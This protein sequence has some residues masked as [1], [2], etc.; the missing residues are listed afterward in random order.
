MELHQTLSDAEF[1]S[2]FRACTLNPAL[3][4]HEAHLR[5]AWIHIRQYGIEQ[6]IKN[7]NAQLLKFVAHVGATDKFNKTVTICSAVCGASFYQAIRFRQLSGFYP[8]VSET[9][10]RF[11][12]V[13]A[14]TLRF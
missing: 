2:Q 12:G 11:P 13:N 7:V 8:G 6:A 14:C 5:L 9:Q 10:D 4:T 1:E 3:F